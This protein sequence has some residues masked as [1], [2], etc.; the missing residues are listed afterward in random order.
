MAHC[1]RRTARK[2]PIK[3]ETQSCNV[4][5]RLPLVS[6]VT[7]SLNSERFIGRTI[8]S[9][10]AQS[11]PN[12]E[13][14]V[15]DGSST[16]GTLA[17]L[18]QYRDR[19]QYVSAPDGGV[20]DAVNKGF[21]KSQGSILGWLNSDDTYRP[22]A[23]DRAV[24]RLLHVSEAAVVYG[25]AIW[26]DEHDVVLGKYPTRTP[27]MSSMLEQECSICQPACFI[28]REAFE[29]IGCLDT[30]LH[31]AFDYDLWIR[32]SRQYPF[33][34]VDEC[35][36][37]SRMH[38]GTITLGQRESVFEENIWLLRRHFGYVPVNWIY[39]YLSFLRDGRDQFFYPLRHSGLVYL[40]ALA[41]GMCYNFRHPWRYW[42]EWFS[43]IQGLREEVD[44]SSQYR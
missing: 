33:T 3:E 28:R 37:E 15:M 25:E 19:L 23:V 18:E 9:V 43:R 39:G 1:L 6:V 2:I 29:R 44:V 16:D 20:A 21:Y 10:L 24:Q 34:A 42:R 35:L 8:E 26:I 4:M 17:I 7:P 31:F 27:F 32:L 40:A 14:I 38:R 11:Y 12:L 41:L 5:D 22:E 36:A 13:Y 30:S